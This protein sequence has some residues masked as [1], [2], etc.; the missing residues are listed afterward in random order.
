MSTTFNL[1]DLIF[2]TFTF[3]FVITAFF[4]GF[5]KEMFALLNWILAFVIS[6]LLAPYAAKFII[7]Y[8]HNSAVADILA[9]III[10]ITIFL[11]CA[12]S[13]SGL[14][15][16]LKEKIPRIFDRSL[17]IFYGLIKTLLVFGIFYSLI[18]NSYR[19]LAQNNSSTKK[20]AK[21]SANLP[22]WLKEAKC[23]NILKLAGNV[24]DPAA[25]MIFDAVTKNFDNKVVKSQS[26]EEKSSLDEKINELT[27]STDETDKIADFASGK[28][29]TKNS[30]NS[31]YSKK[32]IEKMN[33][34]IEIIEK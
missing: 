16:I 13:T 7:T 20:E 3:I 6:Y 8:Y 23:Y 22:S 25:K 24:L 14:C 15:K 11:I 17:G 30:G 9:R 19:L 28:A 33:R 4:R 32:D 26:L 12:I 18:A 10:F 31:G 5:V 1:L 27:K 34:L 21:I 2:I 29:A